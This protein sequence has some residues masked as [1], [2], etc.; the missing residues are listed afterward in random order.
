MH[1]PASWFRKTW[2]TRR[3]VRELKNAHN[4]ITVQ[5]R[6]HVYMNFFHHKDLGNHLL[7]LCPKSWNT[8]YLFTE[9]EVGSRH[10]TWYS[11]YCT[12]CRTTPYSNYCMHCQIL[13]TIQWLLC[14]VPDTKHY[15]GCYAHFQTLNIIEWFLCT[16]PDSVHW[17]WRLHSSRL[18]TLNMATAQFPTQYTKYGD[19]KV[20]DSVH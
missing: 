9:W 20:P 11:G 3:R 7:Q 18:S 15:S 6:T 8:L 1:D 12:H 17:I 2:F 16:V 5:N 13:N 14:A 10:G 19:C 4:S